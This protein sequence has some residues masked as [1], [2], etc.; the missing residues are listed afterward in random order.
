MPVVTPGHSGRRHRRSKPASLK[1]LVHQFRIP[2]QSK[3]VGR[4]CHDSLAKNMRNGRVREKSRAL[5][6]LQISPMHVAIGVENHLK[7]D[8]RLFRPARFAIENPSNFHPRVFL[9][10]FLRGPRIS[11]RR[12]AAVRFG[13][14]RWFA[15][16]RGGC[17]GRLGNTGSD[18]G[19]SDGGQK[20]RRRLLRW[21]RTR[22]FIGRRRQLLVRLAFLFCGQAEM[23]PL[24]EFFRD[25]FHRRHPVQLPFLA[26]PPQIYFGS[27]V[28]SR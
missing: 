6:R 3:L 21:I 18:D 13:P 1:C 11:E 23:P 7:Q 10:Q 25:V 16:I 22:R 12:Q 8:F 24:P 17:L 20:I 4:T 15:V 19:I 28:I 2:S 5:C 27:I 14:F 26:C 9:E